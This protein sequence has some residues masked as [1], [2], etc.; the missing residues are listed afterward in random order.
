[1]IFGADVHDLKGH[2][3]NFVQKKFA[4]ILWPL[5]GVPEKVENTSMRSIL[6]PYCK[7][8]GEG[9]S[10]EAGRRSCLRFLGRAMAPKP[11]DQH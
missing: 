4:L 9:D 2:R 11:M 5:P 1:M 10:I 8:P 3:K 7:P 6:V